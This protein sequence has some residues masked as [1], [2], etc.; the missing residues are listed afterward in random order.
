[1]LIVIFLLC[2]DRFQSLRGTSL[3]AE[4]IHRGIGLNV[5]KSADLWKKTKKT[6]KHFISEYFDLK[7][8]IGV[9]VRQE[10]T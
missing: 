1:M 2:K 8:I 3:Y 5:L 6:A 10:K 4:V 9:L 7:A